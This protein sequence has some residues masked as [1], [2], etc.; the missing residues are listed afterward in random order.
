MNKPTFYSVGWIDKEG[1]RKASQAQE[2]RVQFGGAMTTK[3]GTQLLPRRR[4]SF[5]D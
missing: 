4:K 5:I 1:R 3:K 2:G